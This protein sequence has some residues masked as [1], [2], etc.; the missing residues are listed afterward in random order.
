MET[1]AAAVFRRTALVPEIS[2][3]YAKFVSA[4]PGL[5]RRDADKASN[6]YTLR[7]MLTREG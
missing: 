2:A 1:D 6:R 4:T 3:L 5:F 7:Y